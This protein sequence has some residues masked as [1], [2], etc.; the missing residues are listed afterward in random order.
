[1]ASKEK[2]TKEQ[3]QLLKMHGQTVAVTDDDLAKRFPEYDALRKQVRQTIARREQDRPAPLPKLSVFV[4]TDPNP[5]MHHLL[6]RGQHN[7]PGEKV[8][9]GVPAAFCSMANTY[10][11]AP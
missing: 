6:R 4:E 2:Q 3:Q 7:R 11:V 9:P 10:R 8:Q 5:P 1:N